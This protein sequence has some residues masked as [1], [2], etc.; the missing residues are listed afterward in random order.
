MRRRTI[1]VA[2]A[3]LTFGIGMGVWLINP[4]R[5][6]PRRATEPLRVT[7]STRK[8]AASPKVPFEHYLVTVENASR[9]TV[10]GYALGYA[11]NHPGVDDDRNPYPSGINFTFPAPEIQA[12]RPGESQTMPLPADGL[13]ADELGRKVWVDFVHFRGGG[14]W[15]ANQSRRDG[16]ARE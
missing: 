10:R 12:L 5:W 7:L 14:N 15:G 8:M 3:L 16:Y 4:V 9:R 2:I 6:E 1:H 13:P 11:C